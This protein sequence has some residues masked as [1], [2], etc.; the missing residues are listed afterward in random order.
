MP[1]INRTSWECTL[2]GQEVWVGPG[3]HPL[4]VTLAEF[5]P[6]PVMTVD[7]RIVHRCELAA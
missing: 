4:T 3:K 2:C 7:G 5:G 1:K 6:S